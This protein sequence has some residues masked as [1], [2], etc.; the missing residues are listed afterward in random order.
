M[1]DDKAG[2]ERLDHAI[3]AVLSS[4][5]VS[6]KVTQKSLAEKLGWSRNQV[7]NVENGRRALQMTE[8]FMIAKALNVSPIAL[9]DGVL[10]YE[11]SSPSQN[12]IFCMQYLETSIQEKP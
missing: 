9:V 7:A 2:R 10:R 8:F 1:S 6:L 11:G 12:G 4:S 3:R 5:R